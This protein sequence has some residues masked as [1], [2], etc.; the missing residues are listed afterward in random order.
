M[1]DST[2]T[3]PVVYGE[4]KDEEYM[5]QRSGYGLRRAVV[6]A[7]SVAGFGMMAAMAGGAVA[8]DKGGA[9]EEY[10]NATPKCSAKQD[11]SNDRKCGDTEREPRAEPTRVQPATAPTGPAITRSRN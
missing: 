7:A 6:M 3:G 8:A 1:V 5:F 4:K 10:L 2:L 9:H 11:W